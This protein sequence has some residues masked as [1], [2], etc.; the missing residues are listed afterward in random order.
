[1]AFDSQRVALAKD[2]VLVT[3]RA[4]ASGGA[5]VRALDPRN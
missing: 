5:Q 4:I 3:D 1:M 2:A